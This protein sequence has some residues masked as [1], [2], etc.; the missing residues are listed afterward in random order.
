MKATLAG[1]IFTKGMGLTTAQSQAVIWCKYW[2][3]G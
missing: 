3:G 1:V 2:L